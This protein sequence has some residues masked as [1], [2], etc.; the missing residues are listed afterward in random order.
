MG[1]ISPEYFHTGK[2]THETDVY[3]F[4]V[5][6]THGPRSQAFNSFLL[7]LAIA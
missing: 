6:C 3:G 2:A 1:Y 4:G 5:V 7:G